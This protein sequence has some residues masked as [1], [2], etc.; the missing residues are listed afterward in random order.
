MASFVS[1]GFFGQ[2]VLQAGFSDVVLRMPQ[3]A[4]IDQAFPLSVLL[5][6][7]VVA[8]SFIGIHPFVSV[9]TYCIS[10]SGSDLVIGSERFIS[11]VRLASWPI[12]TAASPFSGMVL[13]ISSFT[14][15]TPFRVG[16]QNNWRYCPYVSASTLAVLNIFIMLLAFNT[17]R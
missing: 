8:L 2:A 10:L 16:L 17:F 5:F 6:S 3:Y 12:T 15:E 13:Y 11:M 9:L 1:A 7:F 14:S 4:G